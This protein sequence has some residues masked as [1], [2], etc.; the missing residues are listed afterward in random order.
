MR[1]LAI[2]LAGTAALT[3]ASAANATVGLI[4]CTMNCQGPTTTGDTTTIGYS[5]T[6]LAT[7]TFTESLT[8]LN[9]LPGLY[10][11]TLTTSTAAVDFTSAVLSD[12][13]NSWDLHKFIDDGT[14]E[15]WSFDNPP[16]NQYSIGDG[17]YTLTIM[18]NNNGA[19]SLGGTV[20]INAVPEPA[21]WAMMLI[22]F[23]AIGASMRRRRTRFAVRQFA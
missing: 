10:S 9:D 18:G 17:T 12:G 13:V 20:T 4:S 15:Y 11:I 16:S 7:P 6:G 1:K 14:N 19:S 2:A 21:A 22:G 23:G 5:D 3:F 8:F